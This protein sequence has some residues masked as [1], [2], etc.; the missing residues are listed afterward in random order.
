MNTAKNL[1]MYVLKSG[2]LSL[3]TLN[4][5]VG[6]TAKGALIQPLASQKTSGSPI[7]LLVIAVRRK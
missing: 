5:A 1:A 2:W 4:S 6:S 3:E 7:N